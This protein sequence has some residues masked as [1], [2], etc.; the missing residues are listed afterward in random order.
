MNVCIEDGAIYQIGQQI[1][2]NRTSCKACT[3][4]EDKDP[5]TGF[6]TFVCKPVLCMIHCP[7]GY[8][9]EA[10][11][12]DCCG[13]CVQKSCIV[14]A[15]DGSNYVL[16]PG[17]SRF[18]SDDN[19]TR[20]TCEVY[21]NTFITSSNTQVCPTIDAKECTS[22]LF[23]KTPDGCCSI[24][25]APK[26][27]R[28]QTNVTEITQNGCSANVSLSYCEGLCPSYRKI[29]ETSFQMEGECVCCLETEITETEVELVFRLLSRWSSSGR[30][31]CTTLRLVR[32]G[33]VIAYVFIVLASNNTS[34]DVHHVN[35]SRSWVSQQ[36]QSV[37]QFLGNFP[38]DLIAIVLVM[39]EAERIGIVPPIFESLTLD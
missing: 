12:S 10:S 39:P 22:G 32:P 2:A 30:R 34:L 26:T 13:T 4:S 6:N 24:C 27:C 31:C 20:Y 28:V 14:K 21:E 17:E 25:K 18:L 9:Y 29:S 19:C 33:S 16:K 36:M 37:L 11:N 35:Y 15:P 3:C 7:E 38:K 23:E 1:L 8:D 5:T